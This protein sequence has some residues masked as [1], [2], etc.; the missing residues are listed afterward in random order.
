MKEVFVFALLV[1]YLPLNEGQDLT[2]LETVNG[3][4]ETES[5]RCGVFFSGKNKGDKPRMKIFIIPKRFETSCPAKNPKEYEKYCGDLF[6]KV[7]SKITWR[8]P[9]KKRSGFNVG[10]DLCALVKKE[11]GIR[12]LPN[13]RFPRG[14]EV[15]FYY[16]YCSD[17]TWYDT[18][19]RIKT[20][21]CCD[22][23]QRYVDC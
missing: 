3:L 12:K 23:N 15:G 16:N 8:T 14:L 20:N 17:I 4:E 1:A 6:N 18:G 13:K 7:K 2:D 22:T 5:F 21:L 11:A 19:N 9:S 10:D